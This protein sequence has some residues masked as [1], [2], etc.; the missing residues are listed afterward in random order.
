MNL[1]HRRPADNPRRAVCADGQLALLRDPVDLGRPRA[2]TDLG[3]QVQGYRSAARRLHRQVLDRRQPL[4]RILVERH[5]DRDL[6]IA[7]REFSAVL[8]DITQRRD[9]DR[10]GERAGRH[11]KVRSQIEPRLDDDLGTLEIAGNAWRDDGG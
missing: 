1:S 4:P 8:I 6:T 2:E 10:V 7:E 9:P 3:D 5:P 11:A